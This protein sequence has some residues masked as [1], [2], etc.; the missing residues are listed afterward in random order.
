MKI[1]GKPWAL[2]SRFFFF[3][4]LIGQFSFISAQEYNYSWTPELKL[5]FEHIQ[6]LKLNDAQAMLQSAKLNQPNNLVIPYL[7]DYIFFYTFFITED[8]AGFEDAKDLKEIRLDLLEK[9]PNDKPE[10]AQFQAEVLIHWALV[11]AKFESYFLAAQEVN[12]A[13]KLLK[14]NEKAFP[15]HMPTRR[16]LATLRAGVGTLPK[17][18]KWI[19]KLLSSLEGSVQAGVDELK[20]VV[21]YSN[22]HPDFIYRDESRMLFALVLTHFAADQERAYQMIHEGDFVNDLTPLK[23]FAITNMAQASGKNDEVIELIE[24]YQWNDGSLPIMYL[25][26]MLGIAKLYRNDADADDP[27]LYFVNHFKGQHYIKEAYQKLAWHAL[28]NQ[29]RDGYDR[30]IQFA[31]SE[32]NAIVDEDKQAYLE[33]EEKL[34]PHPTLL[35]ARLL[36]DGG[37]YEK[38]KLV[39]SKTKNETLSYK[40]QMEYDYRLGRIY[41]ELRAFSQALGAFQ[42][43]ILNGEKSPY[44]F[45]CNAALQS[46]L[47][48]EELD[49]L[50]RAKDFFLLSLSMTPD[51]YQNSLHQKAKSGLNRLKS[52]R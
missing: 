19:V 33:A 43:T 21:E 46:G 2:Y 44:Y 1:F 45:A 5:A 47:I 32:G 10:Y 26:Y 48:Y 34:V 15:H 37:Y 36:F 28:I 29:N 39:L 27:L 40:E 42:K 38:A 41:Q 3:M 11:R 23:R 49:M 20:S 52:R 30:F 9:G 51:T 16:M 7:E 22:A 6:R 13:F 31:L 35:Q 18:Y 8:K 14:K 24:G 50:D 25:N 12:K 4:V 17:K